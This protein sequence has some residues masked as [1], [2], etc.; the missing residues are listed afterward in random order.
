MCECATQPLMRNKSG[1]KPHSTKVSRGVTHRA[2]SEWGALCK[3][4]VRSGHSQG[5]LLGVWFPETAKRFF[6][7]LNGST[8]Q[9]EP[10]QSTALLRLQGGSEQRGGDKEKASS[11][12]H[13]GDSAFSGPPNPEPAMPTALSVQG[14]SGRAG[15]FMHQNA[16][17]GYC[18]N[19]TCP[20]SLPWKPS[21]AV[22]AKP[23]PAHTSQGFWHCRSSPHWGFVGLLWIWHPWGSCWWETHLQ[24][25][26]WKGN[27]LLVQ[28]AFSPICFQPAHRFREPVNC[29]Q[30]PGTT[31]FPNVCY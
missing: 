27:V 2:R 20:V 21:K 12:S 5:L 1:E 10:G 29:L 26:S 24:E 19:L 16:K 25:Q 11:I 31:S 17:F 28:Y 22:A 9:Q 7:R 6:H 23:G 18:S 4:R 30:K 3:C 8:W 15:F 13:R 14:T